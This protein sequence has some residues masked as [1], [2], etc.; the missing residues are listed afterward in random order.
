MHSYDLADGI[1]IINNDIAGIRIASIEFDSSNL[2]LFWN[3]FFNLK[4]VRFKSDQYSH[5]DSD[6]DDKFRYLFFAENF[7]AF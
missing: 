7:K 4:P 3:I 5:H 2:F 1:L 6:T